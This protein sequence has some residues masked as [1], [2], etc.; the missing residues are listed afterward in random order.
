VY[1]STLLQA[2]NEPGI[3][4]EWM[5]IRDI[6]V[7]SG[8]VHVFPNSATTAAKGLLGALAGAGARRRVL[9]ARGLGS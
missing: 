9:D 3:T 4:L 8:R 5:R 7:A 6:S 2:L 1:G